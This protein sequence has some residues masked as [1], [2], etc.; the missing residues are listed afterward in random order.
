MLAQVHDTMQAVL[1][2][3]KKNNTVSNTNPTQTLSL[4]QLIN[5]SNQSVADAVKHFAGVVVKDYGGIGGFKTVSVRSLGA[6]H[7]IVLYDGVALN[8]AQSGQI[9]LGKLSLDNI[10]QITLQNGSP[11][12]M[13]SPA[14]AYAAASVLA[15]K[16]TSNQFDTNFK[17]SIQASLKKASFGFYDGSFYASKRIGNIFKTSLLASYLQADGN[18]GFKSYENQAAIAYRI[19]SDIKASKL[20]Y[21]AGF[22]KND[23]NKLLCKTYYYNSKRGLPNAIILF[24]SSTK[25]RL[26]DR[27]FFIQTKWQHT[28]QHKDEFVLLVKYNADRVY[29]VDPSF[30]NS[31]GKL[32]NEFIQKEFYSSFA[33][34]RILSKKFTASFATDANKNKLVRGD[35]FN[36]GFAN[37]TRYHFLSNLTTK[38]SHKKNDI[39]GNLLFTSIVQKVENGTAPKNYF[40]LS[41]TI[42]AITKQIFNSQLNVRAF[43]KNIFRIPSFNDVYYTNF[44]NLLL[45]PEY[46]KQYNVGVTYYKTNVSFLKEISITADAYYNTVTDKIVAVPRQNLFQ[47]TAINIG[48][49]NIKGVDVAV[50]T[51]IEHNNLSI[52]NIDVNYSYQQSKDYTDATSPLYKTQIAYTPKHSGSG[53]LQVI[54]KK[55]IITYSF[56]YASNRYRIGEPNPDNFLAPF[57]SSDCSVAYNFLQKNNIEQKIIFSANNVFNTQ[58]EIVKYYPL[59]RFNYSIKYLLTIHK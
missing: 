6:N 9:D 7:T 54:Y 43:Y 39:Q 22:Y 34:K 19:N 35:V 1:V 17:T 46:A 31:A 42:S 48:K 4:I 10:Y 49:V 12:D 27:N 25:Q 33:Y 11:S 59:P 18:Y 52:F 16:T 32:E 20:E 47:F 41:P 14:K 55:L 28:L 57:T 30:Q 44:G 40:A 36:V 2:I 24:N 15:L 37:P 26:N 50:H 45:K 8:D 58:Y 38:Y 53:T 3:G 29:Y 23:S 21:D 13:L 5:G 51:Q 56:L